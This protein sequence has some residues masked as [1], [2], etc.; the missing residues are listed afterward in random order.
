METWINFED[1]QRNVFLVTKCNDT[2]DKCNKQ[3]YS[4]ELTGVCNKAVMKSWYEYQ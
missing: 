4:T 2:A 3:F 1:D